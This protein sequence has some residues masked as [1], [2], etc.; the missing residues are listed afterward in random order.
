MPALTH[1]DIVSVHSKMGY[2]EVNVYP[3]AN[4]T[5]MQSKHDGAFVTIKDSR[6]KKG[7]HDPFKDDRSPLNY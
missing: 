6:W 2:I 1:K 4:I 7:E 5:I 3:D